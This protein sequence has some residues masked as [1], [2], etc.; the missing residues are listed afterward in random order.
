MLKGEGP[1]P[2][3]PLLQQ[4]V[5]LRDRYPDYL[6]LFQVGDFY[7]CFGEDAE[8]LAR[9]LGLALT[10]KSSKDFTTPMAGIPI[11]AFDAYAERLLKLGFRL[12]VAD[13]VEPAEEAEGLVR[14]E[15]TQLLTPGTLVQESLLPKE[16][17]YLAALATGDGWGVAFLDV[18]TGE[19]KG[20][21]LHGKSALYDELFR[22]R[23]AEV[24]LAPELRENPEFVEEFQ[25]RFP[26]MLSEA[27]FDPVGEGPL[28]LRRAQGALLAYARATQGGT[29]SVRPFRFYD[30]GA[31]MRLP[32][33]TLRALEVFEPLRG[34]DTL[35]GVL[36]ETRTAPG[37]RL[38]Q[39]WL[40]HPLLDPGPL[41]ARLSR[42]ERFV[43][44]GA[45]REGVRRLL[46]RLADLERLAT[47]LELGRAGPRDLA[48]LRRSLALLPEL[49]ALL[50][51]EVGLPDLSAL[52]G[53][54]QAA[55]VEDPPLKLSEG[56]LIR[57][58]YDPHLDLLRRAHR[59][60]VAYFLELEEGEKARTG[61]PTLK[62]GY[63]AVFGYYLE[64]T[65]PYYDRVPP[66]YKPIQTL[67]DRQRYTLPE[68]KE[69]ERE[70][71]RLE[72]QIRRRE[73]EVFLEVRERAKGEVEALR[74]AARVLA[75]LDV[76]AA[77]AEV[78]VR[79]GYTRPRFGGRL[80]IVAG[81]HP[82]VERRTAFVPND[83]EMAGEL[84]L[85]T[86]PNMAG[87]STFLRQTALI[88]L[89]AQVGS[90]VPAEEAELP[91]F[92]RIL[93]RIGASD[94]LAGGRSTFMVEMEEVALILKEA[95]ERS[96]VLL[97]EVGRGTSSLDGV[98]IATAVAE[99]LHERRCYALFAT[100][101]FELTALPLP[102]LK[103]LHVAAKEEEGG[104]TFYHQVLPGP[105]SKS[106]GVEVARL[107]G[108]PPAVVER[109]QALLQAMAARREGLAAEVLERLLA[110]DPDR[111]TP[112][113]A[114]RLLHELRALALGTP[115]GTMKG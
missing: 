33:A 19:F 39:G 51:E 73:E 113:E 54:L 29:L 98:A 69:R 15:V 27:P 25:K 101:Y 8:R 64:V 59:E 45:L 36:D 12:A 115:L 20:T 65:R 85:V 99:A 11:R 110:L 88:A 105:A 114:L 16:A 78:A 72:A 17:N 14:R 91:L 56:G 31:F 44:E 6:L 82:V 107:A 24:L 79:Y 100:H 102:R 86:G 55:L 109:A 94:D 46:F 57:E 106:Y 42:V 52:L 22:H 26:V 77:L 43:R 71:Y 84:V 34:Q 41:E 1:G 47:R 13:Q 81:R 35:F 66:E 63:N 108:L 4:Y 61:I 40:R 21:V 3:P 112:L 75:E 67:K 103:N 80:R 90:F 76:Y 87:K 74:E 83:L 68:L 10:H 23:P 28:A 9:A 5:E 62:V 89:L 95:T 92:D 96:L 58:G 93:T 50:G 60:G 48:A 32:E 49:K 18:S 30:P 104:L 53:E 70:L 111:L 7:E 38:L 2:L 37:R 97:D